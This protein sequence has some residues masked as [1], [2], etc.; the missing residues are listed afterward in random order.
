VLSE[1]DRVGI[2]HVPAPRTK[3]NQDSTEAHGI[4][5]T[6]KIATFGSD[7]IAPFKTFDV[8]L[9]HREPAGHPR[10]VEI[11]EGSMS[12]FLTTARRHAGAQDSSE[13]VRADRHRRVILGHTNEAEYEKL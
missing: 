5:I 13:E 2:G 6:R 11:L 9:Q 4:S 7:S 3:K 8:E 12:R 10:V 1:Q